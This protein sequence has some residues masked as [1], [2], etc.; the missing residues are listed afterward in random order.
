MPPVGFKPSIPETERPKT[1]ALDSTATG[2]GLNLSAYFH[3]GHGWEYV[4]IYLQLP[5]AFIV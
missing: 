3:L 5:Y 2:I 4:E 1:H